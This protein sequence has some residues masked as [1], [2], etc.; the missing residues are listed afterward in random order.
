MQWWKVTFVVLLLGGF[1]LFDGTK[2]QAGFSIEP[3]SKSVPPQR[4]PESSS[5]DRALGIAFVGDLCRY[6]EGGPSGRM[7]KLADFPRWSADRFRVPLAHGPAPLLFN[8]PY[9]I[10]R[11]A[12]P[13]TEFASFS[14]T[15]VAALGQKRWARSEQTQ[16][17]TVQPPV[18]HPPKNLK[19][20]SHASFDVDIRPPSSVVLA[21]IGWGCCLLW[22][23]WRAKF[24][25]HPTS[26]DRQGARRVAGGSLS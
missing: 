19:R 12:N 3:N 7:R 24:D 22:F 16:R 2:A 15:A 1:C 18:S 8:T 13:G 21:I 25:S 14:T 6:P 23:A 17:R 4:K 5:R 11:K 26:R 10:A 20:V 9:G